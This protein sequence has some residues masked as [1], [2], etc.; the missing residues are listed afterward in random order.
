MCRAC[1]CERVL[2]PSHTYTHTHTQPAEAPLAADTGTAPADHSCLRLHGSSS[3]A[4]PTLK[5]GQTYGEG[6]PLLS[7][8]TLDGVHRPLCFSA[9][10]LCSPRPHSTGGPLHLT[11]GGKKKVGVCCS[12]VFRRRRRAQR[13]VLDGWLE[14]RLG[15]GEV[16]AG[17]GRRWRRRQI[18]PD[19][20]VHPG[21]Y[22]FSFCSEF[23]KSTTA[24]EKEGGG[25]AREPPVR[26]Y[27]GRVSS[28]LLWPT[29]L[30][31]GVVGHCRAEPNS[32]GRL[33]RR[34]DRFI[35]VF[36]RP[37]S[38]LER[39][40]F[41]RSATRLRGLLTSPCFLSRQRSPS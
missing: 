7:N 19:Y 32:R 15:A 35:S 21:Q 33:T 31:R 16:P 34:R 37:E 11:G 23:L 20:P 18:S 28:P 25:Q 41:S 30:H 27:R 17:G 1:V 26:G 24:K 10:Y 2:K 8:R 29:T 3:A 5:H 38:R 22:A 40:V 4:L 36:F 39:T 9:T 14:G 12:L 13:S 6:A